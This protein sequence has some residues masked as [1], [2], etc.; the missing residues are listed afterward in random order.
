MAQPATAGTNTHFES[1]PS[2]NSNTG[3][4]FTVNTVGGYQGVARNSSADMGKAVPTGT[5][6]GAA[7]AGVSQTVQV[8]NT[9]FA[10]KNPA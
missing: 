5:P 9:L 4:W 8:V 1:I 10:L 2:I 7:S 3:V 6:N